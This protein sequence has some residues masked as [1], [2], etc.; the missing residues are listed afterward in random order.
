[1]LRIRSPNNGLRPHQPFSSLLLTMTSKEFRDQLGQ[2]CLQSPNHALLPVTWPPLVLIN[3]PPPPR[4][5]I[6]PPQHRDSTVDRLCV[7]TR[8]NGRNVH[9]GHTE[10]ASL[11]SMLIA[12][13]FCHKRKKK[14]DFRYPDCSACARGGCDVIPPPGTQVASALVPRDQLETRQNLLRW[15]EEIVRR[16]LG[17]TVAE[18][19][20]GSNVNGVYDPDCDDRFKRNSLVPRAAH[21]APLSTTPTIMLSPAL[22]SSTSTP[23]GLA[24]IATEPA[25]AGR[26]ELPS[27][28]E[29]LRDQIEKRRPSVPPPAVAPRLARKY[30]DSLCHQ[31]Q[32]LP[33][34][35]CFGHLR[36]I[37]IGDVPAPEMHNTYHIIIAIALLIGTAE[38]AQATDFYQARQETLSHAVQN[39]DFPSIRMLLGM[40]L[41]RP[42]IGDQHWF[43]QSTAVFHHHE[44]EIARWAIWNLYNLDRLIARP[45][46]RPFGPWGS[47]LTTSALADYGS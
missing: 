6:P 42:R 16:T 45:L 30:F 1:M 20:T 17:I 8:L 11:H 25:T 40:A 5:H 15:L 10:H 2:L 23:P 27:A 41:S 31:H 39:E 43:G 12:C 26:V 44:E 34:S 4:W 33:R 24:V 19:A 47:P 29:I 18:L 9:D 28:G 35:D 32:L 13:E 22:N 7:A 46:S 38:P 37:C 14:C 36:Q 21:A 3:H